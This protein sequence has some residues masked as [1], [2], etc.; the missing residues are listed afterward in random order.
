MDYPHEIIKKYITNN[1]NSGV[2]SLRCYFISGWD[3]SDDVT[4]EELAQ[5]AD[6]MGAPQLP[7][8]GRQESLQ[9]I[10]NELMFG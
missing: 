10:I 1:N 7:S 3:L 2:F 8:S 4:L 5:Y 9:S 6:N